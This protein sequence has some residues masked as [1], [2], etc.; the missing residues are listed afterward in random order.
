[1]RRNNVLG[2][3]VGYSLSQFNPALSA[4]DGW[5][6]S[7]AGWLGLLGVRGL[8]YVVPTRDRAVTL[9][10]GFPFVMQFHREV[11]PEEANFRRYSPGATTV[12]AKSL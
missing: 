3:T 10:A 11:N 2:C 8:K 9:D 1:M 7:K 12:Y 4:V 6:Y 5:T